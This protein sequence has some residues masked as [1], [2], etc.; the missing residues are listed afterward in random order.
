M[1]TG[2]E[3]LDP[4]LPCGGLFFFFFYCSAFCRTR[5]GLLCSTLV[6]H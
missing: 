5:G 6:A 1:R 2:R 4:L 3:K